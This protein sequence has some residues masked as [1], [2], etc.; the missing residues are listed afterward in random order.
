MRYYWIYNTPVDFDDI[1]LVSDGEYL[2]GLEFIKDGQVKDIDTGPEGYF[3]EAITYLDQYF[4]HEIPDLVPSY[5]FE[6]LTSFQKE[7]YEIL[8][9]IGYGEMISY[10]EIANRIAETRGIRKM[11][12]QA[13]G[14]ALGRNPICIIVPCH[15]VVGTDGSLVGYGGG[16][17]NK[18]KLLELE[19][20]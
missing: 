19:R 9:T 20:R 17:Q 14:N 6:K 16:L 2:T 4:H 10:G 1:L 3:T 7:V 5:R 18:E 8:L 15:R 12:A 13:V 11:S